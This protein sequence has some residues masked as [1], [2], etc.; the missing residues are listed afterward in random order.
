MTMG[1]LRARKRPLA[2]SAGY[3]P[4]IAS[5]T[6]HLRN[7][8]A[9]VPAGEQRMPPTSPSHRSESTPSLRNARRHS[10]KEQG[11]SPTSS[12]SSAAPRPNSRFKKGRRAQSEPSP[13]PHRGT[14]RRL[15]VPHRPKRTTAKAPPL[16]VVGKNPYLPVRVKSSSTR[17]R[18]TRA[19]TATPPRTPRTPRTPV[20]PRKTTEAPTLTR[21]KKP[22]RSQ[23]HRASPP[24]TLAF[25]QGLTIP[26]FAHRPA[27]ARSHS[28]P[29]PRKTRLTRNSTGRATTKSFSRRK[30]ARN[31]S[32]GRPPSRTG[33]ARSSSVESSDK[34]VPRH[35]TPNFKTMA[36][37]YKHHQKPR[38]AEPPDLRGRWMGRGLS[39]SSLL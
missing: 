22:R 25:R 1:Q 14:S 28:H 4:F 13:T 27:R 33:S 6:R 35:F 31:S 9:P 11:A 21:W 7:G 29:Y 37:R 38:P 16:P 30:S 39:T 8:G 12:A 17:A 18:R 32:K 34:E 2:L 24:T 3:S 23:S 19:S 5:L 20:T 26:A 15:S 10:L 36:A